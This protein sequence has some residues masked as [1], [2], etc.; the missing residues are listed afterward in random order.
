M[1]NNYLEWFHRPMW[2][3]LLSQQLMVI[4]PLLLGFYF[5][6]WQEKQHE[7]YTLQD[8]IGEQKHNT[9]LS[10]QRLTELPSLTDIQ[11]QIQRITAELGPDSYLSTQSDP[12]QNV[13]PQNTFSP[14]ATV[15]KRLHLPLTHS[16]SQLMEWKSQ[17]ENDHV[18][19]HIMLSLNYDQFLHFLSEIQQLQPPL[20]IKHLTITP[21]DDWLTVR[22]VLS[23]M[24][25]PEMVPSNS[26]HEEKS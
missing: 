20:L 6:V 21:V 25:L 15:L 16:G 18:F 19:W 5:F 14:N 22:I 12:T 7:I 9:T 3:L 24:P 13:S 11:Q 4:I 23:D 17:K 10:Q 1:N 2:Q 8:S 26:G